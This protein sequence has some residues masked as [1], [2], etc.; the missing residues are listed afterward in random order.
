MP[1]KKIKSHV[2]KTVFRVVCVGASAGGLEALVSFLKFLPKNIN[3][4]FVLIQ[5]LEPLHKS[6]LPEI[7][8]RE[9]ALVIREAKN[10]DKIEASNFYVIP[11]NTLMAV[12][13]GRLLITSRVSRKDGKY[14][15]IDFFMTSLALELGNKSIGIILSGTGSDGTEGLKAIKSKGGITFAQDEKT[16]RYYGMPGSAV[17]SGAVDAVLEPEEIAKSLSRVTEPGS[18]I[19][20]KR[21]PRPR[22]KAK[23]GLAMILDLLKNRA[24]VD[25]AHYKQTTV[26]RRIAR[27]MSYR[28]IG[29]Y[30][31]YLLCLKKDPVEADALLKDILIPVT[32]FFRDPEVF[33][34]FR[35]VVFPRETKKQRGKKTIRVWVPACSTGEEVYSIAITL[36]EFLEKKRAPLLVQIFGTD[37]S[38]ANIEKARAGTYAEDI[39]GHVSAER[40]RRFFVKTEKGYKISK[41][42][43][44]LCIFARHN[45]TS[46]PP[47]SNMDIVSCRNLLI[48]LDAVFQNKAL[49]M[50]HY[51]VKPEGFLILGNSESVAS[52]PDHF[53]IADKK[54]KIFRKKAAAGRLIREVMPSAAVRKQA[55]KGRDDMKKKTKPGMAVKPTVLAY[56]GK[57]ESAGT[58][59]GKKRVSAKTTGESGEKDIVKLKKE[60]ART[61][62]RLNAISEEKDTANEELK[63]A[64]EEIQ[65]GNEEL[66]SMN[67]ELETAK[68]ELQSTNEELLTLNEELMNKNAELTQLNS[69]LGNVF[70]STNIPMIIVG[71]DLRIKRFTPSARKVMN[72][73]PTDVDRP[74][75][76]I[77]LNIDIADMEQSILQVIE[78]MTPK[79]SEVRDRDG[80]WYSVRI[81]PYRTVDNRI[82]GAIIAMIDIDAIKRSREEIQSALDYSRAIIETM[83]EPLVVLDRDVRVLSANKAFYDTFALEESEV[84]GRLLYGLCGGQWDNR[85]FRRLIEEILPEESRFNDLELVFD[86]PDLGRRVMLVNGRRIQ[87]RDTDSRMTL[88]VMEDVTERNKAEALVRRDNEQLEKT[89]RERSRELAE[90]QVKL[91]RAKHLSNIGTMA[92][93]IAHELRSTLTSIKMAVYNIRKKISDPIIDKNLL[94]ID[95]KINEGTQIIGN[96][97]S[98]SRIKVSRF[99][100]VRINDLLESCIADVKERASRQ[101]VEI[102]ENMEPTKE[103]AIDVDGTQMREV[104]SNILSN[105]LEAIRPSSGVI[106]IGTG[107][108]SASLSVVIKD[109]G[110][111]IE[112]KNL[113]KVT[114]PFFTTK[115]KGT[116]LGLA[117]C[118][119]I[120]L[121]HDGAIAIESELGK[122]TAVRITLPI[123]L[124]TGNP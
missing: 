43:R 38:E 116:G 69:D 62:D 30:R 9:A 20:P 106:E 118:S 7:L 55:M 104:F 6:A 79:D 89:V 15:P 94:T 102:R 82:D 76:D 107:I 86:V 73:I 17:A 80:R 63:A 23:N 111:G 10:N 87:V 96:V 28:G 64:Y 3:M 100:S 45:I 2:N 18:V 105:S 46:D 75:G 11:P 97:L 27:R 83:R 35:D 13:H 41:Q 32:S 92:A 51:A 77:K 50:L 65:S 113:K 37:V 4:A 22:G 58:G 29:D 36:C 25:F 117:I 44:D 74:L 66:Q 54:N 31:D 115:A 26:S 114:D 122:G 47:L 59:I 84:P 34:A 33:A 57:T 124:N 78:D 95:A 90:S 1:V 21:M 71:N 14:L 91:E 60:Y 120:L 112:E 108:D 98:F 19:S 61:I 85:K 109:N 42:V 49:A 56:P 53:T 67:E 110:D 12:S 93:T 8:S 16:A 123:R 24:G 121:M 39:S 5:H 81:R 119:Q 99:E 40:L 68:E 70:A 48:Y 101:G 103:V 72:L 88:L 52:L